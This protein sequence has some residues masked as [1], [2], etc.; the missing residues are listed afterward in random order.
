MLG[1]KSGSPHHYV[2]REPGARAQ[3]LGTKQEGVPVAP[4]S[5]FEVHSGGGGGWGDPALRSPDARRRDRRDG[6]A[7]RRTGRG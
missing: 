3:V 1:G 2:L 4:G 5:T 7:T 6:I